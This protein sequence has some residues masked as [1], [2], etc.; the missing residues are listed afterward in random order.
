V[1]LLDYIQEESWCRTRRLEKIVFEYRRVGVELRLKEIVFEWLPINT[2]LLTNVFHSFSLYGDGCVR[3]VSGGL[4][5]LTLF[6]TAPFPGP[7]AFCQ[8]CALCS[9]VLAMVNFNV[10]KLC[11]LRS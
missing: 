2:R 4:P 7:Q 8:L 3:R 10:D 6:S 1:T 9:K 5:S 11:L